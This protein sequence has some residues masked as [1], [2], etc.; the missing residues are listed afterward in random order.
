MGVCV[1]KEFA[2]AEGSR[3]EVKGPR[4]VLVEE[5]RADPG[6]PLRRCLWHGAEAR[7]TRANALASSR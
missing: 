1:A 7:P 5:V 4:D 6:V 2:E 3:E